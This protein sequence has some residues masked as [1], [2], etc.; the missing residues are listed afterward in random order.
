MVLCRVAVG[1]RVGAVPGPGR[2]GT[3]ALSISRRGAARLR[4]CRFCRFC[5]VCQQ[6]ASADGS[7]VPTRSPG[8]PRRRGVNVRLPRGPPRCAAAGA[9]RHGPC[10]PRIF[11]AGP[12]RSGPVRPSSPRRQI[13]LEIRRMGRNGSDALRILLT[14]GRA[15]KAPGPPLG[16]AGRG[17]EGPLASSRRSK[18]RIWSRNDGQCCQR[19]A[20][21]VRG[22]HTRGQQVRGTRS[23]VRTPRPFA[24]ASRY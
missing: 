24:T 6:A 13:R 3:T 12:R 1:R 4:V 22:A 15:R 20:S 18:S 5:R 21:R 11:T 17:G 14:A 19:H 2:T 23:P 10:C 16:R 8:G 7:G 9:G